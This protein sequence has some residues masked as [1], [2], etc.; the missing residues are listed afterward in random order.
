VLFLSLPRPLLDFP[1]ISSNQEGVK[2]D[3]VKERG[4]AKED[5]TGNLSIRLRRV[6]VTIVAVEKQ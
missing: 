3:R 5:K 2:E 1:S 6:R 4:G